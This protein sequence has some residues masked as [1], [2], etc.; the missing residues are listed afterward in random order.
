MIHTKK[1]WFSLVLAM[2]IVL[3]LSLTGLF[4]MEYMVP[5]SRSVKWIENASQAFYE[6]QSWVEESVLRVYSWSLWTNHSKLYW[7][8]Q[9]FEFNF[10]W[11]WSTI[12]ASWQW[13]WL[14]D[15]FSRLSQN[16]PISL[17]IWWNNFHTAWS[18][19]AIEIKTPNGVWLDITPNDEI[20]FVQISW[21]WGTLY[22]W[23]WELLKESEVTGSSINL[24]DRD[25]ET[26]TWSVV[27]FRDYYSDIWCQN[28]GFECILKISL[29]RPLISNS[30]V[31]V[32]FLEYRISTSDD[33][34]FQNPT[35][36][37]QWKS[38]WFTKTLEVFIPQEVTSSA[39]DFTV[40]Q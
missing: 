34:P 13:N 16:E 27:T 10:I 31:S 39:F 24:L 33:I 35:V 17:Q 21:N 26:L 25:G 15:N 8:I 4:L 22:S 18:S 11:N 28:T 2:W 32:P 23:S 1:T 20:I 30:W 36:L 6:S 3:L 5:F 40:L 19:I 14:D 29:I 37:S 9:D 38:Y 7:E 12:P